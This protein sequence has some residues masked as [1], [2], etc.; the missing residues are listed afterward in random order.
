MHQVHHD[1]PARDVKRRRG[2][3]VDAVEAGANAA[4]RRVEKNPPQVQVIRRVAEVGAPFTSAGSLSFDPRLV[5]LLDLLESSHGPLPRVLVHLLMMVWTEEKE[6][7]VVVYVCL[8]QLS[9][10]AGPARLRATMWAIV[11]IRFPLASRR[12]QRHRGIAYIPPERSQI[13]IA[14][15]R[16]TP[17][18]VSSQRAGASRPKRNRLSVPARRRAMLAR[19]SSTTATAASAPKTITGHGSPRSAATTGSDAAARIDASEA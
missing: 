11:P 13:W 16:E 10:S 17:I 12:S 19:C 3:E 5:P 15:R 7:V 4:C 14:V 18:D 8:V 6:I 1:I 9:R 2:D